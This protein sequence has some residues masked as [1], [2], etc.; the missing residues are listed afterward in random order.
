MPD[1]YQI[2]VKGYLDLDWSA[3]FDGF[4]EIG[5]R[6]VPQVALLPIGAYYPDTY[7]TVHTNPEEAVKAFVETG[8]RWMVPMHYGTFPLG[9]EPM[10]EPLKRLRAEAHRVGIDNRVRVLEEGETMRIEASS[11]N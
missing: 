2:R 10:D 8:A 4:K 1:H 5:Q 6:L 11:P 3:W 9:R 7:R